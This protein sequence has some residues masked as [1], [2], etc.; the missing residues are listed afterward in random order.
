MLHGVDKLLIF[1]AA[2]CYLMRVFCHTGY[3][4][5]SRCFRSHASCCLGYRWSKPCKAQKSSEQ[6]Q[7][8]G[9]TN[10]SLFPINQDMVWL[11]TSQ[12]SNKLQIACMYAMFHVLGEPWKY[13]N[14]I[15]AQNQYKK[16]QDLDEQA[17][18]KISF[19]VWHLENG[20]MFM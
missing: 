9:D 11:N 5:H 13:F 3:K 15:S 7:S 8:K 10:I 4:R 6:K 19:S 2:W 16:W 1:I 20:Q 14:R 18:C 12:K 17:G